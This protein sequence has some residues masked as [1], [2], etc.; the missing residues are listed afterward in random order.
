MLGLKRVTT[1]AKEALGKLQTP[2]RAHRPDGPWERVAH[3]PTRD[4]LNASLPARAPRKAQAL[5]HFPQTP[6]SKCRPHQFQKRKEGH[7]L[8]PGK[9][10]V[11]LSLSADDTHKDLKN[12]PPK[13]Q[14]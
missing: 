4:M 2:G 12:L 5:H 10:E 14:K 6:F 3:T 8:K 7:G 13:T 9:E 11:R 1:A